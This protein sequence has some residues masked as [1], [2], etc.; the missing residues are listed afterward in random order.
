M[1]TL[2]CPFDCCLKDPTRE[3]G[4][5]VWAKLAPPVEPPPPPVVPVAPAPGPALVRRGYALPFCR[6]CTVL[7]KNGTYVA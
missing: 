2:P 1:P 4:V 6:K 7:M 3:V 5:S